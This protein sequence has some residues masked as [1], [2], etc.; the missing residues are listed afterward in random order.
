[1]LDV[2]E[3]RELVHSAEWSC[4]TPFLRVI[5]I[6]VSLYIKCRKKGCI[7]RCQHASVPLLILSTAKTFFFCHCTYCGAHKGERL[8]EMAGAATVDIQL[9]R[10]N[11]A[12]VWVALMRSEST[13]SIQWFIKDHAFSPSCGLAL[14]P[15]PSPVSNLDCITIVRYTTNEGPVRIQYKCLVPIFVFPEIFKIEL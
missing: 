10:V 9:V 1:M 12:W 11:L 4:W 3:R 8:K 5:F 2:C 7:C 6:S 15:T 13:H 14:P